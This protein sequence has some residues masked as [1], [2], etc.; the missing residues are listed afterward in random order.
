MTLRLH[1]S[2]TMRK[3][4][5]I[6]QNTLLKARILVQNIRVGLMNINRIFLDGETI[7]KICGFVFESIF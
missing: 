6:Y 1:W 3:M 7:K 5:S 4:S 2:D